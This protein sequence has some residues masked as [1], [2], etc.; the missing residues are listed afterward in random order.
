MGIS[1]AEYPNPFDPTSPFR[2]AFGFLA[3]LALDT[4]NGAGRAVVNVHPSPAASAGGGRPLGSISFGLG[5]V[6][7]SADP[8]ASPPV[9][10]LRYPTLAE[11]QAEPDF[12]AAY[13]V[14][15]N[16]LYSALIATHPGLAGSVLAT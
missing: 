12:V 5:E 13:A 14:V 9:P 3:G 6:F 2:P 1:I 11:L 4:V 15:A 10:E 16:R 8:D 7:R